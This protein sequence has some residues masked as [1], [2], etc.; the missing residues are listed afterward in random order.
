MYAPTAPD[1]HLSEGALLHIGRRRCD[2]EQV[3]RSTGDEDD[4]GSMLGSGFLS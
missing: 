2:L 3:H 4:L 1:M